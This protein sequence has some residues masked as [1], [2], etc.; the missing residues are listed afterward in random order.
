L[1]IIILALVGLVA[2]WIPATRASQILPADV[3]R[4]S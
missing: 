1:A 4:E 2:T 3:L